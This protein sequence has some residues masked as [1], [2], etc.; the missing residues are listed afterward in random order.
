MQRNVTAGRR[1]VTVVVAAS[2]AL[3]GLAALIAR[4]LCQLFRFLFQQFIEGFFYA[5]S[6]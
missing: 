4:S 2:V 1:K 3:A 5:A 6:D